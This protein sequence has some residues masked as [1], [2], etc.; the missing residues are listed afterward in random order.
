MVKHNGDLIRRMDHGAVRNAG[1]GWQPARLLA[2]LDDNR[3]IEVK[4][5]GRLWEWVWDGEYLNY[6]PRPRLHR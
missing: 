2:G 4:Q 6:T 5:D 3:F 1:W